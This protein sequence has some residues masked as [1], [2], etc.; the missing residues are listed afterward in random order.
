MDK[1]L[2]RKNGS[3]VYPPMPL[4]KR[5]LEALLLYFVIKIN[6]V[7]LKGKRY[8][9]CDD[10]KEYFRGGEWLGEHMVLFM[11]RDLLKCNVCGKHF[12]GGE[13]LRE[14]MLLFMK[15][16]WSIVMFVGSTSEEGSTSEIIWCYSWR[17]F[18]S[19]V[20]FGGRTAEVGTILGDI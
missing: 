15:G 9:H 11:K 3:M 14:H 2:F 5:G 6:V 17:F 18:F 4:M 19:N 16:V 1:I 8:T 7:L 13:Y 12:K 20:M 10:C